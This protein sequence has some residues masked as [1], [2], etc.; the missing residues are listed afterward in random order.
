MLPFEVELRPGEP[1][2]R[3]IVFA[4]TRAIVSGVL[5][6]GASFP[7]VRELSQEL[8]INPNTAHKV[9]SELTRSGLLEVRPGIG[10]VVAKGRE[11]SP[12]E[13]R[14]LLSESVEA[15]V[16][17]AVRLGLERNDLHDAIA[18]RW[19]ELFAG[20]RGGP[21]RSDAVSP[22]S[23]AAKAGA[24]RGRESTESTKEGPG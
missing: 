16:V 8:K 4:A 20:A 10:T 5:P 19:E 24:G 12:E 9:V 6:S 11:P 1:P 14:S 22:D 2:F 7:S 23:G 15:L 17:E 13:L 21:P 3:Q 18:A